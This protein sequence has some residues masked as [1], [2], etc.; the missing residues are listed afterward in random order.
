[1]TQLIMNTCSLTVFQKLIYA[2]FLYSAISIIALVGSAFY[3]ILNIL[4]L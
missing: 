2:T 1:M 4:T 3:N